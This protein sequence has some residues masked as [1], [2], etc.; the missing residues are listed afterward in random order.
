MVLN[1]P[2]A[3]GLR[4]NLSKH[5][6][7]GVQNQPL[8]TV[9]LFLWSHR[10]FFLFG[11][12]FLAGDAWP[13]RR[14]KIFSPRGD[15]MSAVPTFDRPFLPR[16]SP[17]AIFSCFF[18]G[19]MPV[20]HASMMTGKWFSFLR[21]RGGVGFPFD[22]PRRR[23][24]GKSFPARPRA[25]SLAE[26]NVIATAAIAPQ[27]CTPVHAAHPGGLARNVSADHPSSGTMQ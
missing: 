25:V 16:V 4:F 22:F 11:G 9:I 21:S 26:G 7:Y 18:K 6:A 1:H 23:I 17:Q 3:P 8:L 5:R 13:I 24:V 15:R 2:R 20:V 27:T 12:I 19:E 10:G 14:S